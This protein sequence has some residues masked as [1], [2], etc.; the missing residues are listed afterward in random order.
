MERIGSW[1]GSAGNVESRARP[2][3]PRL[4]EFIRK[5]QAL[6]SS[7]V[8][9]EHGPADELR[10][11]CQERGTVDRHSYVQDDDGEFIR[12]LRHDAEQ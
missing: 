5:T 1:R 9:D 12:R 4:T 10:E 7:A 3:T 2:L 6:T 11:R 8:K